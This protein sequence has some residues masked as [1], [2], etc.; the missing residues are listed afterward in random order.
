MDSSICHLLG[1]SEYTQ[2][3][4]ARGACFQLLWNIGKYRSRER[5]FT[6]HVDDHGTP[7]DSVITVLY[8]TVD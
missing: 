3:C 2:G 1:A 4:A 5:K 6:F 8:K 7:V